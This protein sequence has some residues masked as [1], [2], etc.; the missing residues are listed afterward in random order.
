M[1]VFTKATVTMRDDDAR[2]NQLPKILARGSKLSLFVICAIAQVCCAAVMAALLQLLKVL[3]DTY[4]AV[5]P[6]CSEDVEVSASQLAQRLA[7]L[8]AHHKH[9]LL[10]V[11]KHQC[12]LKRTE[13]LPA[14]CSKC[15]THE[16]SSGFDQR[17]SSQQGRYAVA[18]GTTAA[19]TLLLQ[20]QPVAAALELAQR[21]RRCCYCFHELPVAVAR[22]TYSCCSEA[23]YAAV[24]SSPQQISACSGAVGLLPAELRIALLLAQLHTPKQIGVLQVSS[25]LSLMH[26]QTAMACYIYIYN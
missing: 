1:R 4:S 21:T 19:G 6:E 2:V 16:S 15:S 22:S 5:A 18:S 14:S 26:Y 13:Q 20:D 24:T 7:Q 10:A 17:W 3:A 8:F 11:L 25:C 23:C 12:V 9:A